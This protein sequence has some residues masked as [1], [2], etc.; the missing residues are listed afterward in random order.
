MIELCGFARKKYK[1][2]ASSAAQHALDF[3]HQPNVSLSIKFVS[4]REIRRL[5]REFRQI[6]RV[7]DVLSFPSTDVVAGDTV[8]DTEYIGDMA[9]CL[10][11]AKQQGKEYGGGTLAEIRK[12]VVH[13]V[14]H[15]FG[16]DHI[17][18]E[19]YAVMNKKEQEIEKYILN[20]EN[21]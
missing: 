5:N 20:L 10:A 15:L 18:D 12:L 16:Y 14:L 17:K 8:A 21:K 13:S 3:L 6:D 7:T 9:L 11:K 4:K 2:V 19:D 1:L